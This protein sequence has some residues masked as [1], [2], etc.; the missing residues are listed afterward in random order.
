MMGF[1]RYA[2][3][4][5][6]LTIAK[7][8]P[9]S[10]AVP[11]VM[12]LGGIWRGELPVAGGQQE[13]TISVVSLTAGGYFAALDVP[14]QHLNR[15][16]VEVAMQGDSVTF[17]VPQV[18]SRF[19]ARYDI[20]RMELVGTWTKEGRRTPLVLY[21][22]PMPTVGQTKGRR[23]M[24][25]N[26]EEVAFQNPQAKVQLAGTLT[27]PL[28][29]GPFP[30]VVL[31]SDVGAQ[32]RDGTEADGNYRLLGALADGLTRHGVVVLRYDDRGVGKSG[33]K[34]SNTTTEMRTADVQAALN[35][36]R[37]R[38]EVDIARVGAIGHGEGANVALL[39]ATQPLPPKFVVALAGYGLPGQQTQLRQLVNEL[40]TQG[41]PPTKV[42]AAYERRRTMYDVIRLATLPQARAIVAN[43]LRQDCEGMDPKAVRAEVAELTSPWQRAFL[44]F[45]PLA[46]LDQV[47]CPVLLLSGTSD[48][49]APAARHLRTLAKELKSANHAVT[50]KKVPGVNHL[51]QPPRISWTLL[52]TDLMPLLSPVVQ[53]TVNTWITGLTPETTKL[54]N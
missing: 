23:P 21:H 46:T 3:F 54:K 34:T 41:T 43:M 18:G 39:A 52:N 47:Q 15:L 29:K 45:D 19:S 1:L 13:T 38:P 26:E 35:Y 10:A 40:R 48:D 20:D 12:G 2:F 8:M 22:N 14:A 7:A 33:G 17:W 49:V 28:G 44:E 25:Y 53:T 16:N 32:D 50:V 5:L 51:L 11:V 4:T 24:F 6:G 30:A 42:E 37:T 31:L 36:L 9:L 27:M